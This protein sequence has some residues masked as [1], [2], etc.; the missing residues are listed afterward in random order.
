MGY[1]DNKNWDLIQAMLQAEASGKAPRLFSS[2]RTLFGIPSELD[3]ELATYAHAEEQSGCGVDK[4]AVSF[5]NEE[6]VA[7]GHQGHEAEECTD[8][9]AAQRSGNDKCTNLK[10]ITHPLDPVFD[11]HSR[12]LILG[13]MPSPKSRE[14]GFYYNHPQNRFWPVMARI[15]NEVQP[16]TN[17]EKRLFALSHHIALWDVL[18]SCEI[19]GAKDVSIAQCIPN[20]LSL[21]T[22]K[23]PLRSIF[24]TGAKAAELYDRYCKGQTGIDCVRL[25]STSPANAAYSLERLTQAYQQIVTAVEG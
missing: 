3:R 19:D 10:R 1:A 21:I 13:T 2:Q 5:D 8:G 4:D 18:A 17:E 6:K 20:D 14:T 16:V 15:F 11:E 22:S 7:R 23:A 12:V 24:C 9:L 25:P